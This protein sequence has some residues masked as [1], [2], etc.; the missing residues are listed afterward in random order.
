MSQQSK[1]TSCSQGL[2]AFFS[3]PNSKGLLASLQ[4]F[5]QIDECNTAAY[6]AP[7]VAMQPLPSP[8]F[9]S[10]IAGVGPA[11]GTPTLPAIQGAIAYAQQNQKINAN[12]KV[13]VVLVTDG[14][15]NDCNS[16]V[17]N[18]SAAAQAVASSIPT[19]VIGIG[20]TSSLDAIAAAGGTGQA[21]IVS[22]TNPQQTATD[23]QNALASIKGS[24]LGCEFQV[25]T[26]PAGQTVDYTKVNVVYTPSS[27]QPDTLTYNASCSGNGQGWHYDN[28][29]APTKIE[30]CQASCTTIQ[31][32]AS[33]KI[34]IE[35]GC[36]T[37]GGVQ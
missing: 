36:D 26:A 35:L 13:A 20:T 10:A 30:I 33:A 16:S 23:F 27:G 29:K 21:F 24:T 1:W 15:P 11:G 17:Q 8:S 4:F 5:M 3:D 31:G 12:A 22:T 14:D 9:Q 7:L 37:L 28:P 18:V 19:Y 34:D 32:D 25:P 6:Q 2:D